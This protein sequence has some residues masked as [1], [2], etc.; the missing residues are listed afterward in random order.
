LWQWSRH[1][2]KT[3]EGTTV[4]KEY[5]LQT[6]KDVVDDLSSKAPK[7]NKYQLAARY[8]ALQITGEDYADFLT[9]LLYNEITTVSGS[10]AKL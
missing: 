4:T 5:N 8:F 1:G 9:T 6:L 7:G 10:A 2:V 3:A